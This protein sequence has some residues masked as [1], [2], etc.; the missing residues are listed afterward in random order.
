[1][2]WKCRTMVLLAAGLVVGCT[3]K[4]GD[5][6]GA[7]SGNGSG[8]SSVGSGNSGVPA[9]QGSSGGSGA[10]EVIIGAPGTGV[11]FCT[12]SGVAITSQV[13]RLT[14]AQYD[15]TIADLLGVQTL[16][17]ANN[18][19]PS[20]I[21]A[22]DQSGG[23]TD[24]AWSSYQ[25]VADMI[26][27]Q[28]MADP[29]LAKNFMKCT[30]TGDGTQCLQNTIVDFGRRAFRRPLSPD[31]I[32]R[33]NQIVA[34]GASMSAS[35]SAQDIATT[36][37]YMFLISPSFLTR[38][39]TNTTADSS[40][41][42]QLSSYEV[43]QRLSYMLWGSIP[44]DALNSAADNNMLTT[45]A[46]I[47][48]QAQRMLTDD[49]ARLK[50]ADFHRYYILMAPNTRW[51]NINKDTSLFPDFDPSMVP[52]LEQE[53][54][55][56]FDG[57]SMVKKGTFQ[58]LILSP[59]AYVN[60][61]TAPMYGLDPSGFTTDFQETT[62]DSSQRPGFMT[63]VGFLNAYAFYNRSSPIHRGAFIMKQVLGMPIGSPPPGASQTALPAASAD[64]DTNRKQVDAQTGGDACAGCH[65]GYINPAGF[66]MESFN[67]V[68]TWQ[69]TEQSTGAPIDSTSDV[70]IDN[71]T[72]HVTGPADLM[73]K[74]AASKLAQHRYA[75]FLT[76]YLYEREDD[77]NDCGTVNALAAKIAPG[78][79]T[80]QNLVTDLTQTIQFRT[81]A[82]GAA[83]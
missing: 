55:K 69:T 19:Q 3:G 39:E 1:M 2:E 40:G 41:N 15:R 58:D 68:G 21:L 42:F 81:R 74:I 49:K 14:N 59:I 61:A 79:Y 31:E 9:A 51:D 62:L 77:P 78:G 16:T 64:L 65:H 32:S 67:A 56:F 72:V 11:S 34:N 44:D 5:P 83:Q 26:S 6:G 13:P 82:V 54:E 7:S 28:V 71:Q 57:I 52:T 4:I 10:T 36:V 35:S 24:L 27:Q 23:L 73:A 45:P 70:V 37:L 76:S 17:A 30:P 60:K 50:M 75:E 33:F 43:A 8:G 25:S 66:A 80:I 46:Q 38:A 20:T 47:L 48:N 53:E 63:R 22:T 29:T 12:S 18:V